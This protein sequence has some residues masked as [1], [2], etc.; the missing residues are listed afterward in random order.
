M[1]LFSIFS[2]EQMMKQKRWF[3]IG[4]GVAALVV[5]W[6]CV[7]HE[8]PAADGMLQSPVVEFGEVAPERQIDT[9]FLSAR[10]TEAPASTAGRAADKKQAKKAKAK[11]TTPNGAVRS[12]RAPLPPAGVRAPA[13]PRLAAQP[14]VR[15]AP[16]GQI[17]HSKKPKKSVPGRG[18]FNNNRANPAA[19]A[20]DVPSNQAGENPGR[21]GGGFPAAAPFWNNG[22]VGRTTPFD[23]IDTPDSPSPEDLDEDL[24]DEV[25]KERPVGPGLEQIARE[26]GVDPDDLPGGQD[27][28][29]DALEAE[30][31]VIEDQLRDQLSPEQL[32][33][34]EREQS[35]TDAWWGL[36]VSRMMAQQDEEVRGSIGGTGVQDENE[37]RGSI[38]GTG[39]SVREVVDAQGSIGGTGVQDENETRGS[40]GGT[41]VSVREVVDTQGSIGGTG[42]TDNPDDAD[43]G[44]T[45]RQPAENMARP[46][47]STPKD[48]T[49]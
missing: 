45:L 34:A 9:S 21:N 40:I 6:G 44:G 16:P 33:L 30:L 23:P 42:R 8:E 20:A 10:V 48:K 26:Y 24:I 31:A 4:L 29:D 35:T 14:L 15:Q 36:T 22:R 17:K 5:A 12:N 43:D 1:E 32:D 18:R 25:R 19:A 11:P 49:K 3:G 47:I 38:G 39:V 37:T 27:L 13:S 46:N 28:D 2:A 41:G 7:Q